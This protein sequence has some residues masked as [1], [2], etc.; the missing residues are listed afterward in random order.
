[1]N[2]KEQDPNQYQWLIACK[3]DA[4]VGLMVLDIGFGILRQL[5]VL[6]KFQRQRLG[7]AQEFGLQVLQHYPSIC[8]L[9]A[10]THC[11]NQASQHLLK[12]FGFQLLAEENPEF[13]ARH[14]LTYFCDLTVPAQPPLCK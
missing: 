2:I 12:K 10:S 14:Y 8:R 6:P 9:K 5:A 4:L 13:P 11:Q 3:A 1:M 7:L